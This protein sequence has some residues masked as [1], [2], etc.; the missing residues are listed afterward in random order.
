MDGGGSMG[1]RVLSL[2]RRW[3]TTK[4]GLQWSAVSQ[5]SSY[6]LEREREVGE[7]QAAPKKRS[8][9]CAVA[10]LTRNRVG[11]GVF[12]KSSEGRWTP[13][14]GS[15]QMVA[16]GVKGGGGV[17]W[18]CQG[19]TKRR[20]GERGGSM[21][22]RSPLGAEEGEKRW[23][24]GS[25]WGSCRRRRQHGRGTAARAQCWTV[26]MTRAWTQCIVMREREG[27]EE[28]ADR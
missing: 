22:A 12:A 20:G 21:F 3:L 23:K 9:N 15:G 26:T 6:S 4:K 10:A 25:G 28:V 1:R 8:K 13:A 24:T 16:A 17:P 18:G 27:G 2:A 14:S 7:R 19:Q 11:G 5:C